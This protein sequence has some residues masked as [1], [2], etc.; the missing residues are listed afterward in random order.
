MQNNSIYLRTGNFLLFILIGTLSLAF[1]FSGCAAKKEL[2]AV[3][4]ERNQLEADLSECRQKNSSLQSRV[5]ELEGM[6]SQLNQMKNENQ[7]LESQLNAAENRIDQLQQKEPD[8]PE[9]MTEG[10]VFKV[11]IGAFEK[12]E[13]PEDLDTSV[14]LDI[15]NRDGMKAIVVGQFRDY[16]QADAL[17]NHLRDMGVSE[18]WIV[19][20]RDGQR[21]ELKDV[22]DTIEE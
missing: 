5:N 15:E 10:I 18:A 12:R 19:P 3:Q 20:Y 9:E 8:C 1:L 16:F 2:A 4:E 22:L 17:Q 7:N 21:V 14:N 6:E 11:Q 13:I